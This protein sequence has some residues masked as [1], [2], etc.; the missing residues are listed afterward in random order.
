[1]PEILKLRM[2]GFANG[3][4][5]ATL[6]RGILRRFTTMHMKTTLLCLALT[7]GLLSAEEPAVFNELKLKDGTVLKAAKVL[8]EQPD[9]LYIEHHDGAAKVKFENLPE[10]VQKQFGYDAEA[11][12]RFV[13]ERDTEQAAKD[14]ADF[15]EK[16]EAMLAAQKAKLEE[17]VRRGREDF[18]AILATGEYSYPQL[19]QLLQ[20]SIAALKKAGRDDLAKT[21]E[22]DRQMLRQREITRPA[23][24]LRKERDQLAA[25][26]RDLENQLMKLNN[27]PAP[28]AETSTVVWPVYVD[29][30]VYIP[31]TVVVDHP[32]DRP[33]VCPPP[34]STPS[35]PRLTPFSPARPVV[36]GPAMPN[37]TPRQTSIPM[38]PAVRTRPASSGAQVQGAHLWKK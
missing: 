36:S 27:Q 35:T 14:A 23:E 7:T 25:R 28:P 8:R 34:G 18:F 30:P 24:S 26:V 13:E 4:S 1:M 32:V 6:R 12:A 2:N 16:S 21:L 9:G 3:P 22:D 37:N 11:A 19:D 29:R 5:G 38:A 33:S 15:R 31:H 17:D 20:D 10:A